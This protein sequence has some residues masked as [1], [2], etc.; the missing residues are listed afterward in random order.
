[1]T[2]VLNTRS[3]ADGVLHLAIPVNGAEQDYEVSVN[4]RPKPEFDPE[5]WREWVLSMS[6]SWE[7][8]FERPPQ[9]EYE[10]RLPL[11]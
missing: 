2:M 9:G 6:G 7:G 5:E 10:E 11:S 3:N 4:V 8:E 1:M